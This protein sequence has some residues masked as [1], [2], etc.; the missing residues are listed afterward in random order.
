MLF[1]YEGL[2][3]LKIDVDR[4]YYEFKKMFFDKYDL[5]NKSTIITFFTSLENICLEKIFNGR[6]G[7]LAE[8]LSVFKEGIKRNIYHDDTSNFNIY[9]F[10]NIVLSAIS[11]NDISWLED[12]LRDHAGSISIEFREDMINFA[13]GLIYFERK[14]FSEALEIISRIGDKAEI[15]KFTLYTLKLKIYYETGE[16]SS[17]EYLLDTYHHFLN[18]NRFVSERF[19]RSNKEFLRAYQTLIR[20][21]TGEINMSGL[22]ELKKTVNEN[23]Y[24]KEKS[25]LKEKAKELEK[26]TGRNN[27]Y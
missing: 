2:A 12:L 13:Y 21:T 22:S 25:W 23:N 20:L 5:L 7:F 15:F 24:V 11:N 8:Q 18:Q 19:K 27:Q 9:L 16:L 10:R 14:K 4:Y 17:A 1:L 26:K 3:F 6:S